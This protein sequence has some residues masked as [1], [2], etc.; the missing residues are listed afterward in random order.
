[1]AVLVMGR[2]IQQ[3]LPHE[4]TKHGGC[5]LFPLA[6][7]PSPPLAGRAGEGEAASHAQAASP[8]PPSPA[9]GGGSATALPLHCLCPLAPLRRGRHQLRA[10]R[11]YVGKR[12]EP[13]D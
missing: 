13:L 3:V 1:M 12:V 4:A 7:A 6:P 10:Q 8:S 11:P 5:A 9:S 2:R